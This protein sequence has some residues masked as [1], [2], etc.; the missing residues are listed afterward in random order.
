[1]ST[2]EAVSLAASFPA[3]RVRRTRQLFI[4]TAA[5]FFTWPSGAAR[6]GWWLVNAFERETRQADSAL[7]PRWLS[8]TR[9]CI[10]SEGRSRC[11]YQEPDV[12]GERP[13]RGTNT[14]HRMHAPP[15][16]KTRRP[17]CL[18]CR[19][20]EELW[21]AN[22]TGILL[23]SWRAR[24]LSFISKRT[25]VEESLSRRTPTFLNLPED[26]FCIFRLR[27]WLTTR[28]LPR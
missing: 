19:R 15:T 22:L 20:R 26:Y 16:G 11:P 1:M 21:H 2:P 12:Y 5:P 27:G 25:L 10:T 8:R 28:A 3:I 4:A 14:R 17:P 7:L 23:V 9:L 13:P 24:I 6:D 18:V